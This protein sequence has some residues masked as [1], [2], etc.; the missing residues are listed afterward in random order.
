MGNVYRRYYHDEWAK[1][2][3]DVFAVCSDTN[4]AGLH[5][6]RG[7]I[8]VT[9]CFGSNPFFQHGPVHLSA[10]GRHFAYAESEDATVREEN[11]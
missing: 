3:G 7:A 10:D 2:G 4:D 9:L 11:S 8:E 6:E 1:I 5:D